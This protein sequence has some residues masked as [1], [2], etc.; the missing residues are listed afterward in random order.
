MLSHLSGFPCHSWTNPNIPYIL[1]SFISSEKNEIYFRCRNRFSKVITWVWIIHTGRTLLFSL[2]AGVTFLDY[3][4]QVLCLCYGSRKVNVPFSNPC[5]VKRIFSPHNRC[6]ECHNQ[7]TNGWDI[8]MR[9]ELVLT[10]YPLGG[11]T[12]VT[13]YNQPVRCK[14]AILP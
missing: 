2:M 11:T 6:T 5:F 3:V 10:V 14:R 9:R 7:S 1:T 13:V 12:P 4:W 8:A